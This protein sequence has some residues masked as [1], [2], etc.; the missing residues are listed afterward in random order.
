[1]AA[2][3][4]KEMTKTVSAIFEITK[5]FERFGFSKQE[6]MSLVPFAFQLIKEEKYKKG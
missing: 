4:E 6:S 5:E 1:M 3:I 2:D